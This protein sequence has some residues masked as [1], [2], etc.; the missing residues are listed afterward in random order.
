MRVRTFYLPLTCLSVLLLSVYS[1]VLSA[2]PSL[3]LAGEPN[4]ENFPLVSSLFYAVGADSIAATDITVDQVVVSE[5]GKGRKV[6]SVTCPPSKPPVPISSVLALDVSGSM[7][8][9]INGQSYTRLALVQEGA[10]TWVQELDLQ[11]SECAITTFH[12]RSSLELGFS[13]NRNWLL[14]TIDKISG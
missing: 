3:I 5:N 1:G 7:L 13:S 8:S 10:R 9:K 12:R 6:V 14:S 2:Q 4:A 11:R